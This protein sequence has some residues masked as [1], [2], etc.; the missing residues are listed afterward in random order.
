MRANLRAVQ[1]ALSLPCL[2]EPGSAR[3]LRVRRAEADE[4]R[5]VRELRYSNW[6]SELQL[7]GRAGA[8]QGGLRHGSHARPSPSVVRELE[9]RLRAHP[10][11]GADARPTPSSRRER[12]SSQWCKK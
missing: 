6:P 9:L 3:S 11:D 5:D 1:Q 4:V 7:E 2:P 10:G 12:P 8:T